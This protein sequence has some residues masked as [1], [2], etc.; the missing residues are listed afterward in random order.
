MVWAMLEMSLYDMSFK[1]NPC[2]NIVTCHWHAMTC[3]WDIFSLNS[4]IMPWQKKSAQDMSW[5][6][7]NRHFGWK[8]LKIRELL[9]RA[10]ATKVYLGFCAKP[11][12]FYVWHPM[13]QDYSQM[14]LLFL[15]GIFFD[16]LC[17]LQS[18]FWSQQLLLLTGHKYYDTASSWQHITAALTF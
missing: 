10:N 18:L 12:I 15:T 4:C 14:S 5:L 3:Q 16:C 8:S 17:S 13:T 2:Q 11:V 6:C 9:K 7:N 1:G